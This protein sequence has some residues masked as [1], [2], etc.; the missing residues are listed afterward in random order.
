MSL[1]GVAVDFLEVEIAQV[2]MLGKWARLFTE[3]L[4]LLA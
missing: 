4:T 1:E 2:L 3:L